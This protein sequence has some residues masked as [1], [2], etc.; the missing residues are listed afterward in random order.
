MAWIPTHALKEYRQIDKSMRASCVEA[1]IGEASRMELN[2]NCSLT[3][4]VHGT[5]LEMHFH[6]KQSIY[7]NNA[8]LTTPQQPPH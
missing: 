4:V 7:S 3:P 6:N 5:R 1:A 2:A 8:I